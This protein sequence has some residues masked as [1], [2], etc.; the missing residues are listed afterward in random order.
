MGDVERARDKH[1]RPVY[2]WDECPPAD[3][4]LAVWR[5]KVTSELPLTKGEYVGGHPG[6]PCL[7]GWIESGDWWLHCAE[8][9]PQHAL[10]EPMSSHRYDTMQIASWGIS[11][12]SDDAT[13]VL[14]D[15]GYVDQLEGRLRS[16]RSPTI[17]GEEITLDQPLAEL[18]YGARHLI[19][20]WHSL[21]V[22]RQHASGGPD[23]PSPQ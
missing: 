4:G 6:G 21:R 7:G 14:R 18:L 13:A 17:G 1:G 9:R 19:I 5:N 12:I 15:L 8:C 3:A 22:A 16:M 11:P 20:T 23:G 2:H 10:A